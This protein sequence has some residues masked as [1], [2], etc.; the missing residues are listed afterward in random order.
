MTD[1]IADLINRINN[2][3][4][5]G[6]ETMSVPFSKLKESVLRVLKAEG[7]ITDFK[8]DK[9]NAA[10]EIKLID[11]RRPFTKI[12]RLSK[13][14]RRV[15]TKSKNIPRPKNGYGMV[16]ISTPSGV[17]SGAQA[18]K[19]GLGGEIICEVW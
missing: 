15:Y 12:R 19:N 3:R 5:V 4:A 18:R 9:K 14:G 10:I 11:A 8:D 13:P 2:A 7:Y 16:I 6:K 17:I 1:T